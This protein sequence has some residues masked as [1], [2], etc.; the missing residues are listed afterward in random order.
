MSN[1]LPIIIVNYQNPS[2]TL[3]CLESIAKEEDLNLIKL[4][5]VDVGKNS[6]KASALAKKIIG[7]WPEID[8]LPL[9]KNL[10]FSGANNYGL[11]FSLEKY[12]PE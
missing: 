1:I 11:R 2:N 7:R 4:V 9:K 5:V 8:Y 10:G 3:E 12:Q 6:G